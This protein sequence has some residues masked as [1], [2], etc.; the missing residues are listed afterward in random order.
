M[1]LRLENEGTTVGQ[2]F[3]WCAIRGRIQLKCKI[4]RRGIIPDGVSLHYVLCCL[5]EEDVDHLFCGSTFATRVWVSL[6]NLMRS[7]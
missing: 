4:M 3:S 6:L 7:F 1:L 5:V 2:V